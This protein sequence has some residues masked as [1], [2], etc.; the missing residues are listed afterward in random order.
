MPVLKKVKK[1][2]PKPKPKAV[3]KERQ[4]QR[5]SVNV[6]V[7]IDQS[8]KGVSNR[9][10]PKQSLP[11]T[12]IHFPSNNPVSEIRY[13]P[14]IRYLPSPAIAP[15]DS[16]L[17]MTTE[18]AKP[19]ENILGKA[20]EP[21]KVYR[22][23]FRDAKSVVNTVSSSL[24]DS[25][26]DASQ[27]S[28][29]QVPSI[30]GTVGSVGS[31]LLSEAY[32]EY[33]GVFELAS[34]FSQ[35]NLAKQGVKTAGRLIGD[36]WDSLTVPSNKSAPPPKSI[37]PSLPNDKF[38]TTGNVSKASGSTTYSS[39]V[40]DWLGHDT[41]LD[42]STIPTRSTLPMPSIADTAQSLTSKITPQKVVPKSPPAQ[43]SDEEVPFVAGTV[44]GRVL[45]TNLKIQR[46]KEESEYDRFRRENKGKYTRQGL[47]DAWAKEKE[48][49]KKKKDF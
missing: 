43:I 13:N 32:P 35:S 8:K 21:T 22:S 47:S 12:I 1:A 24:T 49:R 20:Q 7:L 39:N 31:Q 10:A 16:P 45:Q 33:S 3:V 34:R 41:A 26:P 27:P 2:K 11:S 46:Q 38:S 29:Y 14:E 28:G 48:L 9:L 19:T 4:K 44:A 23:P 25:F 15:A 36:A 18:P 37:Q 17:G 30:V 40:Y 5:Q 42:N 6:K